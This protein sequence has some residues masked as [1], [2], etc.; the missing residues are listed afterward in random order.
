[1]L[2]E[3]KDFAVKGNAIDMAI[4]VIIGGAFGKIV[5]SIV[6]DLIMPIFGF[7]T[8]G[9]DFKEL[10][11]VLSQAVV[12]NGVVIKPEAAITYGNFLQNVLD[13]LLI[14]FSIFL[15]IRLLTNAKAKLLQTF[16]ANKEEEEAE[17]DEKQPTTE[18]LLTEI[19]DLL[20][21]KSTPQKD[22]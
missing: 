8:A 16:E 15:F 9:M 22:E 13:F 3:F 18:E 6:N 17:E 12:E 5:T 21:E 2:K 7:L 10:K 4:G 19:R 20:A 1:M 14:S 11:L